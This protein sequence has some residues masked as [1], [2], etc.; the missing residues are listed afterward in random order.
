MAYKRTKA[1]TPYCFQKQLRSY[2]HGQQDINALKVRLKQYQR[3]QTTPLEQKTHCHTTYSPA[4]TV[5]QLTNEQSI[6]EAESSLQWNARTFIVQVS[7]PVQLPADSDYVQ[8][9]S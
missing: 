1:L 8:D 5:S 6:E 4:S 7:S 2:K 9:Q 3:G